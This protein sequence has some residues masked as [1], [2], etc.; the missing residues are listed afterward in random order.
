[1]HLAPAARR[2]SVS[3]GRSRAAPRAAHSPESRVALWLSRVP[4]SAAR[5]P[6]TA[7]PAWGP[8]GRPGV[9]GRSPRPGRGLAAGCRRP[10]SHRVPARQTGSLTSLFTRRTRI[11]VPGRHLVPSPP[12]DHPDIVKGVGGGSA[13]DFLGPTHSVHCILPPSLPNS[14][15][16]PLRN[17]FVPTQQ[18]RKSQLTSALTLKCRVPCRPPPAGAGATGGASPAELPCSRDPVRPRAP[19]FCVWGGGANGGRG[20]RA[21]PP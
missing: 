3:R 9:Q 5:A 15:S 20:R 21:E 10:A 4:C 11:L 18:P 14:R 7:L 2:P 17:T 1:M 12:H 6:G 13:Y 8:R 16:S 19:R